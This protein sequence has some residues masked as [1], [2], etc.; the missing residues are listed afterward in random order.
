MRQDRNRTGRK[1]QI[2]AL[3]GAVLASACC[4]LPPLLMAFGISGGALSATFERLRP[5]TLPVTLLLLGL[6]FWLTYRPRP[7]ANGDGDE[8]LACA[9][10]GDGAWCPP[11]GRRSGLQRT[12][13]VLFPFLAAAILVVAFFPNWVGLLLGGGPSAQAH[14]GQEAVHLEITGMTCEACA[15]SLTHALRRVEGV[16]DASVDAETGEAQVWLRAGNVVA[17][18]RLLAAVAASGPYRARISSSVEDLQV[19]QVDPDGAISLPGGCC[20]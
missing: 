7:R 11:G 13:R 9:Q 16:E 6:A 18:E 14:S 4:W 19:D 15:V 10:A 20:D 5:I 1:V 12:N 3:A 2:A 8:D 17:T